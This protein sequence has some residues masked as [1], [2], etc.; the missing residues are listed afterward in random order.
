MMALRDENLADL[1]RRARELGVSRY[2]ML[3]RDE[4]IE[5]IEEKEERRGRRGA[6]RELAA[7][8]T[9]TPERETELS[10]VES[11]A[12]AEEITGVLDRMP[13][14]TGSCG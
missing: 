10:E 9:E 2:R 5:A 6:T 4:L 3:T 8:E 11:E 12:D 13:R 14:A 7:R 1:H